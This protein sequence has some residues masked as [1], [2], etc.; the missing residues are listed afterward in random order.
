M[1]VTDKS[2]NEHDLF[3]NNGSDFFSK[4]NELRTRRDEWDNGPSSNIGPSF[5]DDGE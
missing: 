2:N 5:E 4:R 1:A 3:T